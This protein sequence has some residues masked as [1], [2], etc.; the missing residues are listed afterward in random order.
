VNYFRS[1]AKDVDTKPT[2]HSR[3]VAVEKDMPH[4]VDLITGSV[5]VFS[6]YRRVKHA[7]ASALMLGIYA[8]RL[9]K[10]ASCAHCKSSQV[11]SSSL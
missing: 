5:T 2:L 11:K 4:C 1:S 3:A 7:P 9:S 6:C 10:A 8:V